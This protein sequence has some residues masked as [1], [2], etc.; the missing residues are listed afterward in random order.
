MA[1]GGGGTAPANTFI[2]TTFTGTGI[3]LAT[4]YFTANQNSIPV[5]TEETANITATGQGQSV[6]TTAVGFKY[7]QN[8]INTYFSA[9]SG[10]IT[11]PMRYQSWSPPP[12][13]GIVMSS[14]NMQ[15]N[16]TNVGTYT[17]TTTGSEGTI[18]VQLPKL[19]AV[20]ADI[21]LGFNGMQYYAATA[22]N[23]QAI[24]YLDV[25]GT[26][27][28]YPQYD[29]ST[30]GIVTINMVGSG[31]FGEVEPDYNG[32]KFYRSGNVQM[33][34][35]NGPDGT[36]NI[37]YSAYAVTS[38][39]NNSPLKNYITGGMTFNRYEDTGYNYQ[40]DTFSTGYTGHEGL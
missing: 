25:T 35:Y 30:T 2:N 11:I 26:D 33:D 10:E 16:F 23:E 6:M 21:Y 20:T 17:T 13:T 29:A 7:A 24:K 9:A 31:K 32:L 34:Y 36:G 5:G 3:G 39:D 37:D 28:P 18:V 15:S 12:V 8:W 14:Y 19:D 4:A 22:D 1:T 27:L 38:Y 40:Y